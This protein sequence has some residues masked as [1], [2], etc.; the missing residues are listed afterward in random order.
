MARQFEKKDPAKAREYCE[1]A[2]KAAPGSDAA[3]EAAERLN[4][5]PK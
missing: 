3:K 4:S 2:A 1:K 5:L